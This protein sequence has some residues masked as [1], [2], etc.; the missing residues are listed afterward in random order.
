MDTASG[1]GW[2]NCF[3]CSAIML[4]ALWLTITLKYKNEN[5]HDNA[6]RW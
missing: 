3:M 5:Q 6:I 2:R 4:A 1:S